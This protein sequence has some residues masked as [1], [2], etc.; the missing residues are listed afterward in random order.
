MLRNLNYFLS[1][2]H[3]QNSFLSICDDKN[4]ETFLRS[5]H[6]KLLLKEIIHQ[7]SGSNI[8]ES[9]TNI[10]AMLKLKQISYQYCKIFVFLNHLGKRTNLIIPQQMR[11]NEKRKMFAIYFLNV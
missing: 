2:S 1:T 3:K 6:E 8:M 9:I 10:N 5:F 11:K 4:V 7:R